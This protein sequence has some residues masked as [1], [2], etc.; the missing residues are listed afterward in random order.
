MILEVSNIDLGNFP[1]AV[2]LKNSL[3]WTIILI[4]LNEHQGK[5]LFIV[6]GKT[7]KGKMIY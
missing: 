4:A 1:I 6:T 5:Q 3:V 2:L 7:C